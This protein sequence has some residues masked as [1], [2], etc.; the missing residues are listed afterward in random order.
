MKTKKKKLLAFS[1]LALIGAFTPMMLISGNTLPALTNPVITLVDYNITPNPHTV[2]YLDGSFLIQEKYELSKDELDEPTQAKLDEVLA[3]KNLSIADLN[4]SKKLSI[5]LV[6]FSKNSDLKTK[7]VN[8]YGSLFNQDVLTKIDAYVLI[9]KEGKITVIGKNSDGLFYGLVSLKDILEQI[10]G[11]SIRNLVIQDYA[12]TAIRG[13]IEGYYG[14]PWTNEDR[15]SLMKF[16]G[17]IKMTSYVFAPKDDPYHS[18]KWFELYP[19]EELKKVKEM[20]EVGRMNKTKF[21]W[22]AHPFMSSQNIG[23]DANKYEERLAK[24]IAKFE[25]LYS[26]GVRQFGVLADDVG[27]VPRQTVI[28]MM[29]SL[30]EWGKKKGDVYDWVFCPAGYNNAWTDMNELSDYDPQFPPEVHIFW[31]GNTVCAPI[32]Q[33]TL[34]NFRTRNLRAGQ[35]K[36]RAPLFW[37]NWP[38]NDINKK[39]LLMGKGELLHTDI[40]VEDLAGVV[41]NPMQEAE[42]SKVALAAIADYSWNVKNFNA[43]K[44]WE[45]SFKYIDENVSDSLFRLANHMSDPAPNGHN[46]VLGESENIASDITT[47]TTNLNSDQP[48]TQANKEKIEEEMSKI[49]YASSDVL[50]NMKNVRFLQQL[51]PFAQSIRDRAKAINMF[52][53]AYEDF[54]N[55]KKASGFEKYQTAIEFYNKANSYKHIIISGMTNTEAGAKRL[56]PFSN[57]LKETTSKLYSDYIFGGAFINS[58]K[59]TYSSKSNTKSIEGNVDNLNDNNL[60][61]GLLYKGHPAKG[62]EYS[63]TLKKPSTIYGIHINQATNNHETDFFKESELKYTKD[64][65]EWLDVETTGKKYTTK[66]IDLYN[67]KLE[68]VL[69]IKLVNTADSSNDRWAGIREF[70]LDFLPKDEPVKLEKLA[71][72]AMTLPEGWTKYSGE[73]TNIY[74]DDEN[75]SCWL[76]TKNDKFLENDAITLELNS[77]SAIGLF[78]V[79]LGKTNKDGD[80]FKKFAL[81]Y[82]TSTELAN[83]K[84]ETL[85]TYTD[86]ET[87]VEF[88][89]SSK[90]LTNVKYIRVRSTEAGVTWVSF[91]NISVYK[92]QEIS[93]TPTISSVTTGPSNEVIQ[94]ADS[95]KSKVFDKNNSTYA[96]FKTGQYAS[97][98]ADRD[99]TTIDAAIGVELANMSEIGKIDILMGRNDSDGDYMQGADLQISEN[100]TTWT[101]L[102]HFDNTRHI[103]YESDR[104]KPKQKAK[105]I[106]IVSTKRH[107]NWIAIREFK[108]EGYSQQVFNTVLETNKTQTGYMV[109]ANYNVKTGVFEAIPVT[110]LVLKP[111]EYITVDL[112]RNSELKE[113][114]FE[115]TNK[116]KLTIELSQNNLVFDNLPTDL[117]TTHKDARYLRIINKGSDDVS[118]DLSKLSVTAHQFQGPSV[119]STNMGNEAGDDKKWKL[120]DNNINTGMKLNNTQTKGQYTIIDLGKETNMKNLKL[121]INDSNP[122]YIR[123]AE[124]YISA[125]NS[126]TDTDW[127]KVITIGD[128]VDNEQSDKDIMNSF[129]D[130]EVSYNTIS[131]SNINKT[132]RYIK[133][134]ITANYAHRWSQINE[135]IWNYDESKKDFLREYTLEDNNKDFVSDSLDSRG[136]TFDALIDQ[137]LNTNYISEKE[138]G[139]LNYIVSTKEQTEANYIRIVSQ[140][141]KNAKVSAILYDETT[142]VKSTVELGKLL[143]SV[144]DFIVPTG[145]KL[146]E[147]KFDWTGEKLNISDLVL[148]KKTG[149][150]TQDKSTLTTLKDSVKAKLNEP[151]IVP[152]DKAKMTE[153]VNAAE[154]LIANNNAGEASITSITKTLEYYN[155]IPTDQLLGDKKTL[156]D[157]LTSNSSVFTKEADY[158]KESFKN[159]KKLKEQIET[160]K[161]DANLRA[162]DVAKLASEFSA[163]LPKLVVDLTQKDR[164]INSYNNLLDLDMDALYYVKEK[165]LLENKAKVLKGL[166]ETSEVKPSSEYVTLLNEIKAIKTKEQFKADFDANKK[167]YPEALST[168]QEDIDKIQQSDITVDNSKIPSMFEIKITELIKDKEHKKVIVKYDLFDKEHQELKAS[169]VK[170]IN[171]DPAVIKKEEEIKTETK[172]V[173]IT[174]NGVNKPDYD[175]KSPSEIKKQDIK[176]SNVDSSK[177]TTKIL[178]VTPDD[179]TGTLKV[180][181]ELTL[182]EDPSIKLAETV[183]LAGFKKLT[184]GGVISPVNPDPGITPVPQKPEVKNNKTRNAWLISISIITGLGL[185]AVVAFLI[186]RKK[187]QA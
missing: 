66:D 47:L 151:K 43:D 147:V 137:D 117:A 105:Y 85:K 63:I 130:H 61:T 33:D 155:T 185:L 38:V 74:D 156:E 162:K 96:H 15:M 102:K 82:S 179:I 65:K 119:V 27:S 56:I 164:A 152:E 76:K 115:A 90:K 148:F 83:A 143:Q 31:T 146:L 180:R 72:K 8:E 142:K 159:V 171:F 50:T 12:D 120:F 13:F 123:D 161:D 87:E 67:I 157:L 141:N 18:S 17:K 175:K 125:T 101:T 40:N 71:I 132:V 129:P 166:I 124:V 73:L 23:S 46:L 113:V 89:A 134:K 24:L 106:R 169:Y 184:S 118:F 68:G 107:K 174:L 186:F 62:D 104:S 30:V 170:T 168:T 11:L 6:D 181:Y 95:E 131:K 136:H 133:I 93:P 36:R 110:G 14:L 140:A 28:N 91:R 59:I 60:G 70:N 34:N 86:G 19:E 128:G 69:G 145:K 77:A 53:E 79:K 116:E 88:D 158:T 177:Y 80:R 144:N 94:I 22:T 78:K 54:K 3:V 149:V 10:N 49:I 112:L 109:R 52:L 150:T 99:W 57:N 48:L 114:L 167:E 121:I 98:H 41:S 7:V 16:G 51:T 39:R 37:L 103:I 127:E 75:S 26:I 35:S 45:N 81:E 172:K 32:I 176:L 163:A 183:S 29:K 173:E 20:V 84:W 21:V 100:N 25:Q 178:D 165:T 139:T 138:T 97:G 9:I 2:N 5:N 135:I 111:N 44:S 58:Q 42:P 1:S 92:P 154:E 122:D 108:V 64:G 187:K 55:D 160:T 182:K 126:T 4:T 153:L